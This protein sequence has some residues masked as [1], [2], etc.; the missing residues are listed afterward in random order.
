[1]TQADLAGLARVHP[2][3]VARWETTATPATP[4]VHDAITTAGAL[5]VSVEDVWG[6]DLARLLQA[7]RE[8]FGDPAPPPDAPRR[9]G[10]PRPKPALAEPLEDEAVG[11]PQT[12]PAGKG[13]VNGRGKS[14]APTKPALAEP[15][16]GDAVGSAQTPSRPK[17]KVNA[18][19]RSGHVS[20][21]EG[22]A[23]ADMVRVVAHTY[24]REHPRPDHALGRA[25]E[26]LHAAL[27]RDY[28]IRRRDDGDGRAQTIHIDRIVR[29][30]QRY[31]KAGD[32]HRTLRK[33]D[34]KV[35]AA[36]DALTHG[37]WKLSRAAVYDAPRYAFD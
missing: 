17:A 32:R 15:L 25:V 35:A 18:R 11:S 6:S 27:P 26:A 20:P 37:R 21:I 8:R 9:R 33:A 2:V 1:M 13:K 28:R 7:E 10:R 19:G 12:T 29:D 5:D 22:P 31:G 23:L 36:M 3:T 24:V 16:E 30:G 14:S 34:P 4:G